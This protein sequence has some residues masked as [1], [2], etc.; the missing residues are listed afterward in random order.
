MNSKE[1]QCEALPSSRVGGRDY[2]FLHSLHD[3]LVQVGALLHLPIYGRGW[4]MYSELD[5]RSG[6]MDGQLAHVVRLAQ[7]VGAHTE[8]VVLCVNPNLQR[9]GSGANGAV[10]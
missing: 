4:R 2:S 8:C 7:S 3:R 10:T 5:W 9:G 6:R 1:S